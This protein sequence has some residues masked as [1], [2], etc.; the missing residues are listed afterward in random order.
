MITSKKQEMLHVK[1][2]Q[3]SFKDKKVLVDVNLSVQSGEIFVLL[4]AN[5]AGKTTLVHILTTISSF[6]NG[7]VRING[8]DLQKNLAAIRAQISL[9]GQFSAV[10]EE[11]TGRENMQMIAD[12][13]HIDHK[14]TTIDSL[15]TCFDLQEASSRLVK[16]YS[17]GMRRRLDIAMSFIGT[18]TLL[19]LD[20]PTTGLDPQ[21]RLATWEMIKELAN[22]G[23]TIFLTT[24][25]LEEAEFLADKIAI[26]HEGE[27][28]LE[29]TPQ[30]IKSLSQINQMTIHV[31]DKQELDILVNHLTDY[32]VTI[33][34]TNL[35]LSFPI[36]SGFQ[37]AFSLLQ[38]ID[39]LP[40]TI[41]RFNQTSATLEDIFLSVVQGGAQ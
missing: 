38:Q 36:K 28:I 15:L 24:Q 27:I 33:D 26:L 4:G 30:Q 13:R 9:T 19:F 35:S 23:R 21:N 32:D 3:K 2:L 41:I 40:V 39:Q 20:E 25:Y 16:E 22:Q 5:G 18:P 1:H 10:D 17:G 37:D 8:C 7:T 11:L 6:D 34:E 12:L 14:K 29:G 31:L